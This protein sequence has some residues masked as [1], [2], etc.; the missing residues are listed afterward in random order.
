MK[1]II[2]N[3]EYNEENILTAV[4]FNF[5]SDFLIKHFQITENLERSDEELVEEAENS[6]EFQDFKSEILP[7]WRNSTTL[8]RR[9]FKVGEEFFLVD[10]VPLR[11]RIETLL[12]QLEGNEKKIATIEYE[13]ATEFDR[14]NDFV[15]QFGQALDMTDEEVDEFFQYCI[16]E[17]WKKH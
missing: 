7:Q 14:M 5:V 3:K 17:G 11:D 16:D 9:R 6:Q 4:V 1:V 12:N 8:S 10:G 15:V 13:Q 2:V